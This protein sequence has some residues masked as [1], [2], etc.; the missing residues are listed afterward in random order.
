M[1]EST[2]CF[3]EASKTTF[4]APTLKHSTERDWPFDFTHVFI[5]A[6]FKSQ[7]LVFEFTSALP[8]FIVCLNDCIPTIPV[9]ASVHVQSWL[10]AARAP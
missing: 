9:I 6:D 5:A 2:P 8:F 1:P 3:V 4:L 10:N 7:E